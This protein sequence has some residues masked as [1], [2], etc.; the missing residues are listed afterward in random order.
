MNEVRNQPGR[1][2]ARGGNLAPD[3]FGLPR[4]PSVRSAQWARQLSSPPSRGT[5]GSNPSP[6]SG[7]SGTNRCR[8]SRRRA[9]S[10]RHAALGPGPDFPILARDLIFEYFPPRG[11]EGSNPPPSSVESG[12]NLTFGKESHRLPSGISPACLHVMGG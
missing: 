10:Q 9:Q 7:E 12:A 6:S 2:R 1:R 3:L 5:E 4:S 11:T 8:V